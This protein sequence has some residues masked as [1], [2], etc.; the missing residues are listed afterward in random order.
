[1]T[2]VQRIAMLLLTSLL[3]VLAVGGYGLWSSSGPSS[4]S[5]MRWAI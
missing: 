4:V 3:A 2:I 5:T 1:M